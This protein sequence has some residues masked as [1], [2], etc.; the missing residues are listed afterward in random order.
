MKKKSVVRNLSWQKGVTMK[1][2][3]GQGTSKGLVKGQGSSKVA[4]PNSKSN[5]KNINSKEYKESEDYNEEED[6]NGWSNSQSE[7]F[8][9]EEEDEQS[10]S[11]VEKSEGHRVCSRGEVIKTRFE[12]IRK[13]PNI[14][15]RV[16]SFCLEVEKFD[17]DQRQVRGDGTIVFGDGGMLSLGA[18]QVWSVLGIP[19]RPNPVPTHVHMRSRRSSG[20][21]LSL[22]GDE[23]DEEDFMTSFMIVCS[24][25]MSWLCDTAGRFQNKFLRDGFRSRCGACVVF[26]LIFYLDHLERVSVQW[27]VYPRIKPINIAYG[28]PHPMIPRKGKGLKGRVEENDVI[29]NVVEKVLTRL[30]PRLVT[31]VEETNTASNGKGSLYT[32]GSGPKEVFMPILEVSKKKGE[33]WWCLAVDFKEKQ[34]WMLDSFVKD[35]F[36]AHA[37]IKTESVQGLDV[38]AGAHPKWEKFVNLKNKVFL[39]DAYNK[40]NVVKDKL[41]GII[42]KERRASKRNGYVTTQ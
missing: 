15:C 26:L 20:K 3:K 14:V 5:G 30:A 7:D 9:D 19:M 23:Q 1:F 17:N 42:P 39:E 31:L 35:P 33:H 40:F 18:K 10:S 2:V 38:L 6:D 28:E 16:E 13:P 12:N 37:D 4:I 8:V 29:S 22:G 21:I 11:E 32:S 24:F 41:E 36:A 25:T 27:G 34:I